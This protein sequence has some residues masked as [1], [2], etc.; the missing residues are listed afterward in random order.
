MQ[1]G[2]NFGRKNVFLHKNIDFVR[3]E[4]S[5]CLVICMLYRTKS[6]RIHRQEHCYCCLKAML[7]ASQSLNDGVL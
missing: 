6:M 7:L 3:S 4:A 1:A 5:F 2:N